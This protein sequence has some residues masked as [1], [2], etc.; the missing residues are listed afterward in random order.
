MAICVPSEQI[1]FMISD[2]RTKL[3]HQKLENLSISKRIENLCKH[4]ILICWL[5]IYLMYGVIEI[6]SCF[7]IIMSRLKLLT[8]S[9]FTFSSNV[10]I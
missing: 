2:R 7:L 8:Y 9:H 6:L 3:N 1:F 10:L 4:K 5:T